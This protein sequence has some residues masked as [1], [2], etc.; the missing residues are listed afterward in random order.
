MI[1]CR[2]AAML[3]VLPPTR[4]SSRLPSGDRKM[5]LDRLSGLAVDRKD[6]LRA[7]RERDH[8]IHLGAQPHIASGQWPRRRFETERA[9]GGPW[10]IHEQVEWA[11]HLRRRQTKLPHPGIEI[12]GA[13]VVVA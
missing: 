8:Q 11:R 3:I 12:V 5:R 1:S 7:C 10:N 13:I 4:P 6:V 2:L 9:I